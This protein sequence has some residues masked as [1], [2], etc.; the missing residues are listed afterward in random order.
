MHPLVSSVYGAVDLSTGSSH[1][2][3]DEHF[4]EL[5]TAPLSAGAQVN[6]ETSGPKGRSR[7]SADALAEQ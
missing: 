2:D 7:Q 3:P 4:G 6:G 1:P 5:L